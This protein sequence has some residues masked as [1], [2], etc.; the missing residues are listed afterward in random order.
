MEANVIKTWGQ[1]EI[2][3]SDA[4]RQIEPVHHYM[5][6]EIDDLRAALNSAQEE[7]AAFKKYA[8]TKQ[9]RWDVIRWAD[10]TRLYAFMTPED[11][12]IVTRLDAQ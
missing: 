7:I 12:A 9:Q 5:A 2:E 4:G 3:D 10:V 6:D 11:E 1:R 8:L